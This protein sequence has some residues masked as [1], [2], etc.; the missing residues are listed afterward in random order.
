MSTPFPPPRL[1]REIQVFN[2]GLRWFSYIPLNS[3]RGA[4]TVNI[5]NEILPPFFAISGIAYSI[6]YGTVLIFIHNIFS[7]RSEMESPKRRE[8]CE[9]TVSPGQQGAIVSPLRQKCQKRESG[10]RERCIH[11]M[12]F[13]LLPTTNKFIVWV[14]FRGFTSCPKFKFDVTTHMIRDKYGLK[15]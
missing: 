2:D 3:S 8:G 15:L 7:T 14:M 10:E 5:T 6:Y 13:Q 9:R 11:T 12:I 1:D 4:T